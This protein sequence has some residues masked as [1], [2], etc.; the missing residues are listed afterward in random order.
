MKRIISLVMALILSGALLAATA[1][2]AAAEDGAPIKVEIVSKK[3]KYLLL[4]KME[5]TATVTNVSDR[6]MTNVTAVAWQGNS[7]HGLKK[8]SSFVV[9]KEIF[10]PNES[11]QFTFYTELRELKG[12]DKLLWPLLWICSKFRGKSV[13]CPPVHGDMSHSDGRMTVPLVSLFRK[14]YDA[15]ANVR[16]W[17]EDPLHPAFP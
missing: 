2:P 16:V 15:T 6:T 5:F 1:I 4:D 9:G 12:L 7:L 13:F 10:A 14:S 11:F 3:Q 17:Y 8:G